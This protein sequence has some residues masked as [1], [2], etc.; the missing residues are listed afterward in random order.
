MPRLDV[1]RPALRVIYDTDDDAHEFDFRRSPDGNKDADILT[2]HANHRAMLRAKV[3][4]K[5]NTEIAEE[6]GC[7][8]NS[9]NRFLESPLGKM[10]LAEMENQLD[11][12]AMESARELVS[13]SREAIGL[14]RQVI[15]GK[16]VVDGE[17]D[18]NG[19]P[20][21]QVPSVRERLSASMTVLDRVNQTAKVT[22]NQNEGVSGLLT[23]ELLASVRQRYLE[24]RNMIPVRA[25]TCD[26][27]DGVEP[28]AE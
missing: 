8:V 22:R 7:H 5:T 23:E 27:V 18:E 25:T 28:E 16:V 11:S 21:V 17:M 10:R 24:S 26:P 2:I 6:L 3:N 12:E 9:V 20:L 15:R 4:C 13:M 1:E 14:V 19:D